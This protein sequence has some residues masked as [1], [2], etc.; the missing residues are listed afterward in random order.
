MSSEKEEF[1][2]RAKELRSRLASDEV[3]MLS[4]RI[5][6]HLRH[7]ING[8]SPVMVYASKPGE[9]DTSGLIDW[10]L[11]R[12]IRVVVPI[13]EQET[14]SLRLSYLRDPGNLRPSTFSVPEPVGHEVPADPS[15]IRLVVVP[16][17]AFDSR[18]YRLGYGAGYYDRFLSLH[19]GMKKIGVAFACQEIEVVPA[20]ENDVPMDIIV[21]ENGSIT[22]A[23]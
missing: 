1:R 7:L 17:I 15:S 20:D 12:G 11:S 2:R 22:I 3:A 8:E 4:A 10:L 16:L 18:G 13:I 19:P 6:G 21:T 14:R 23:S 5:E 9:V